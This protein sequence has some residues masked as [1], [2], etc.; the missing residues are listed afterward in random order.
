MQK[1]GKDK[2]VSSD[3]PFDAKIA[4]CNSD[5]ELTNSVHVKLKEK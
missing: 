4:G 5:V 2:E 1:N 3:K